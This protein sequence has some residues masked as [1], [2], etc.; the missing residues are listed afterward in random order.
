MTTLPA[1]STRYATFDELEGETLS[2]VEIVDTPHDGQVMVFYTSR[3]AEYRMQHYQDCCEAVFIEDIA[4]DLDD[5][6]NT[7]ILMAREATNDT[8]GPINERTE[9]ITDEATLWTFYQL[10]TIKGYVTIRWYGSS[11]GYYS[12]SVSFNRAYEIQG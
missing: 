11:N 10:A 6:L 4:G 7:P 12:I 8:M 5:L 1:A 9:N 2:S 3:G